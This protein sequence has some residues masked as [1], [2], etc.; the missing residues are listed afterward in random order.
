MFWFWLRRLFGFGWVVSFVLCGVVCGCLGCMV[1]FTYVGF[2][3]CDLSVWGLDAA[4]FCMLCGLVVWRFG[5][6]AGFVIVCVG[7]IGCWG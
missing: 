4:W 1:C 6:D 2:V 5:F 3:C 7:W